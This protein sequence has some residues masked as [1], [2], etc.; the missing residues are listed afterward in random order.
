MTTVF[1]RERD[2]ATKEPGTHVLIIGAGAYPHLLGGTGKLARN[3][4]G[5]QQL[6]SPPVSAK[7]L[8]AW[9]A[10]R[11][12]DTPGDV[13]FWN[14][15]VPLATVELLVSPSS[16]LTEE[17]T[18][19]NIESAYEIW[20]NRVKENVQNI[21]IFYFCGH[22][23]AGRNDYVLPAD[24]GKSL[25]PWRDAIDITNTA[26]AV[27]RRANAS[28]Y[29]FIDACRDCKPEA[30]R[31]GAG[32]SSLDEFEPEK[33][34]LSFS[35]L[36][37]WAV[38]DGRQAHAPK[39]GVSRFTSAI[40]KALSG[41]C[42][43]AV[44]EENTWVVTGA[45]L[46]TSIE[47]ILEEEN[48]SLEPRYRQHIEFQRIGSKVFHFE[49]RRP[50]NV[51]TTRSVLPVNLRVR[52]ELE[53]MPGGAALPPMLRE[54]LAE[55]VETGQRS[56]EEIEQ[57][58]DSCVR[59]SKLLAQQLAVERDREVAG[60][61]QALLDAG[62][63]EEAGT[64]FEEL[65][66]EA[67]SRLG[68]YYQSRAEVAWLALSYDSDLLAEEAE[69]WFRRASEHGSLDGHYYLGR[70]LWEK[71]EYNEALQTIREAAWSG[72]NLA[73]EILFEWEK[74]L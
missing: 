12:A 38:G 54:F 39:G 42:A 41:F 31:P 20:I 40:I 52:E 63:L 6:S 46:C 69:K 57:L 28:F 70:L 61:A 10:A 56:L 45:T 24:F 36:M 59:Q 43:E 1:S 3:P 13:G 49:T 16:D 22:G 73:E 37:V 50:Q 60:Q 17:A 51:A 44:P 5:L 23:V 34:V 29:F 48:R 9:F 21:G 66:R 27:R 62:K 25:N 72:H 18:R 19:T 33:D 14:P 67:E 47:R 26:R 64:V 55:V 35:R 2:E 71:G 8:A 58:A 74:G 4:M 15:Y 53:R 65:I 7:D 68:T 32:Q 30:L 11:Q